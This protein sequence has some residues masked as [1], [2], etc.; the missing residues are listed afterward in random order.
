M[1]EYYRKDPDEWYDNR[2][3][4]RADRSYWSWPIL[5]NSARLTDVA[6]AL[7]GLDKSLVLS[8][9][10]LRILSDCRA[11]IAIGMEA[12]G[13]S[14]TKISEAIG[15]D[16]TNTYHTLRVGHNRK[17]IDREFRIK[18]EKLIFKMENKTPKY[19]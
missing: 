16:R 13:M 7:Y 6:C 19:Q 11:L 2:R 18:F 5:D 3:D 10:R 4:E 15:R 17:E 14:H 8:N 1:R 12:M 9:S